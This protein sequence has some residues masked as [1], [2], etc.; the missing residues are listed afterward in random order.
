MHDSF[1]ARLHRKNVYRAAIALLIT[2][3][4]MAAALSAQEAGTLYGP[5]GVSPEAIKQG[6]LGSCY[7]HASIAALAKVAPETLREAI[8]GNPGGGYRVRFVEG[9]VE[10][11]L[12]ED[13]AYGRAH[14]FDRSDG[15][16]VLVL[17][18]GYAQR[19]VRQ[20]LAKS[21][22]QSTF[23]PAYV[24][25]LATGWVAQSG[26]VLLAYDRAIRSVVNQEGIMNKAM[27]QQALARE[28]SSLGVPAAE[29][30]MLSGFLEEKGFFDG[31]TAVVQE[32]GEVF[33]A[34]KSLGQGGIP[35]R[36]MEAFQGAA[37]AGPVANHEQLMVQMGRMRSG[38]VALVVGTMRIACSASAAVLLRV[39][40]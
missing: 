39:R 40:G 25:P 2:A 23:I 31:L 3:C 28:L 18:R 7:F 1:G 34:Y 24:K 19:E 21:I 9:P 11:V 17:M 33:G 15:D 38:K 27:F 10:V 32:N 35:V 29:A 14:S 30:G 36:V 13:L 16:W 20:S 4:G 5:A 6:V 8:S 26:M 12:P 22:E 37:G